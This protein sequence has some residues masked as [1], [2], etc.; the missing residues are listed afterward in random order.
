MRLTRWS[1]IV[2]ARRAIDPAH[3]GAMKSVDATNGRPTGDASLIWC[4]T[5]LALLVA[6]AGCSENG[7][8]P[9]RTATYPPDFIT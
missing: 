3:G 1:A 6:A 7:L 2:A 8:A 5:T 9:L 4:A